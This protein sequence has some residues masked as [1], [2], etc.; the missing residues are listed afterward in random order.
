[1]NILNRLLNLGLGTLGAALMSVLCSVAGIEAVFT[2]VFAPALKAFY[3]WIKPWPQAVEFFDKVLKR[4][5]D[6][7]PPTQ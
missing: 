7:W 4:A 3:G 5:S 2:R 1:M 6:F